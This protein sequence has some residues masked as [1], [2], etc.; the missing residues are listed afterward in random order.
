[1]LK[2]KSKKVLIISITLAVVL[3]VV[4]LFFVYKHFELKLMLSKM[5]INNKESVTK[6]LS[7]CKNDSEILDGIAKAYFDKN[8]EAHGIAVAMHNLLTNKSEHSKKLLVDYYKSQL[9]DEPFIMQFDSVQKTDISFLTLTEYDGAEYGG[10]DGIYCADFDGLI[11][12]KL[13]GIRSQYMFAAADGVYALDMSDN[14]IKHLSRDCYT[15]KT[16]AYNAC[17]F[18]YLNGIYY[19]TNDFKLITPD[20]EYPL[21]DKTPK[22]LRIDGGSVVC[23]LYNEKSE[24]LHSLTLNN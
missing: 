9:A 12:Y 5:D 10:V 17:E 1:M 14:A 23:D 11:K 22:N 24:L 21:G 20:G 6:V 15:V 13:S 8:D 3:L 16:I 19:I 2:T 4:A 7:L 18:A